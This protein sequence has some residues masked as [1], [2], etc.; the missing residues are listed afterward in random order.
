MSGLADA[1]A[2]GP[3]HSN[4]YLK[5]VLGNAAAS[6]SRTNTFLGERYRRIARRRGPK[7][8]A[9][10]VGCSILIIAWHLLTNPDS[11][12]GD[13][14]AGYY[15]NHINPDRKKR[16]YIQELQTLGYRVTLEPAA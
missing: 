16:H 2:P 3:A 15:D 1:V 7:R 13:L 10:A 11:R 4:P 6:A 14:G 5:G 8:A 9:V 12:F